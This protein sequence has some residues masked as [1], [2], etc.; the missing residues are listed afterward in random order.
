MLIFLITDTNVSL[1]SGCWSCCLFNFRLV[2]LLLGKK[3]SSWGENNGAEC[4]YGCPHTHSHGLLKHP[5]DPRPPRQP[6][7]LGHHVPSDRACWQRG[8]YYRALSL[9]SNHCVLFWLS[10]SIR[11][12]RKM[13]YFR[14]YSSLFY[15][16]LLS[17]K[18]H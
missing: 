11:G 9:L 16:L 5:V 6:F 12:H 18:E 1:G 7:I 15:P 2:Y 10:S 8:L 17:L 13:F 4:G 14:S 3:K